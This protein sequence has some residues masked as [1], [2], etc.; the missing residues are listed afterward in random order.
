MNKLIICT[1]CVVLFVLYA[2]DATDLP[3]DPLFHFNE[4]QT[5]NLRV[6]RRI[7]LEEYGIY[8]PEV[9]RK[10]GSTYIIKDN[11]GNFLLKAL[12]SL[13]GKLYKGVHK[14]NGPNEVLSLSSLQLKGDDILV[15]D[16]TKKKINRL[17]FCEKDTA[18]MLEEYK[19]LLVENRPFI[20]ACVGEQT[21]GA[22]FFKTSWINYYNDENE[23]VSSLAFPDF[24]ELNQL[25]EE[26]K[27]LVY[28]STL[29]TVKPD[30][31]KMACATQKAGV[32]AVS[33]CTNNELHE[34]VRLNYF[35]SNVRSNNKQI[36]YTE[37]SK[38]GF[39]DIGCDD[40][41]I[42]L[43]YS[44]RTR[45]EYGAKAHHCQHV[46]IYDWN[47]KPV[48]HLYLDKPLFSMVYDNTANKICGIG[49]DPEGCIL[50]YDL[51]EK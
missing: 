51:D 18:I 5:V 35:P 14:G 7:D 19:A 1:L 41:Y 17:L 36:A 30:N 40:N 10:K 28:L 12:D 43:L 32:I 37:K 4:S 24:Q 34:T 8:K 9:I 6:A 20:I 23:L 27:A 16:I 38:V 25:S 42:Y 48:K 46:L 49:Y 39:C 50:E 47:G 3:K 26:E 31:C 22:G 33:D 29:I 15:Y 2:C 45:E 13:T 21:I 11:S 44:G